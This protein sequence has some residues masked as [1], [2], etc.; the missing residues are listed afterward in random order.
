ML[1]F[2]CRADCSVKNFYLAPDDVGYDVLDMRIM[3]TAED[4]RIDAAK[5]RR[6]QAVNQLSDFAPFRYAVFYHFYES[7]ARNKDKVRV[8]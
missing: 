6:E 1:G 5:I 4:D 7:V 2:S 8:V 3:S